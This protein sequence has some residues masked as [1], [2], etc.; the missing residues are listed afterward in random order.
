M[1]SLAQIISR[2][3]S[4]AAVR[5]HAADEAG[6]PVSP[7]PPPIVRSKDTGV[8]CMPCVPA[9]R[10]PIPRSSP[11][12]QANTGLSDRP[13]EWPGPGSPAKIM[14]G[15]QAPCTQS[16]RAVASPCPPSPTVP[17]PGHGPIVP[18]GIRPRPEP[19]KGACPST[20]DACK[21]APGASLPPAGSGAG[22]SRPAVPGSLQAQHEST[23]R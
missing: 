10:P 22:T 7:V 4:A 2:C 20:D 18:R 14:A 17:K 19:V 16:S 11:P 12:P 6:A 15:P 21:T 9:M 3:R 8:P 1:R 23:P 13:V 5:D